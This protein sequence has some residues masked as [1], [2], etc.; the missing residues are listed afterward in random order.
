MK[1]DPT[2][3]RKAIR[4]KS[5]RQEWQRDAWA[6]YRQIPIVH[7]AHDYYGNVVSR[8][9]LYAGYQSDPDDPPIPLDDLGEASE[10]PE[11]S[12]DATNAAAVDEMQRLDQASDGGL[13]GL[14][15]DFAVNLSLV[16]E[17][18]LYGREDPDSPTGETFAVYST[19][20]FKASES[21]YAIYRPG[22]SSS[23]LGVA[24][25]PD[26]YVLRV[27]RRLRQFRDLA[28]APMMALLDD[29]DNLFLLTR[30]L[31]AI[32]QSR[33]H[34]GILITP[35]E[36]HFAQRATDPNAEGQARDVPFIEQLNQALVTSIQDPA[37]PSAVT[38]FHVDAPAASIGE[39]RWMDLGRGY[40]ENI[41]AQIEGV[42]E[43][44]AGGLDLPPEVITGH[45][46]TTFANAWQIAEET[47]KAHI[48]PLVQVICRALTDGYLK[49][50]LEARGL[51][52]QGYSV[53][54]DPSALIGHPDLFA[55]M[56]EMHT[57]YVVSDDALRRAGGA[58]DDDA[59]EDE[60]IQRRL[61][62][63][64][65]E[66]VTIRE[67]G[68]APAGE[69]QKDPELD[70]GNAGTPAVT[71]TTGKTPPASATTT[72]PKALT[73]AGQRAPALD[74]LGPRLAQIDQDLRAR[75]QTLADSALQRALE[76]AGAMVARKARPGRASSGKLDVKLSELAQH[77]GRDKV[78]AMGLDED[79]L[80]D[81]ELGELEPEYRKLTKRALAA[82]LLAGARAV[83]DGT[84]DEDRQ[85]S[86]S[87][88]QDA[89]IAGG[90]A[91]LSAAVLSAAHDQLFT[92]AQTPAGPGEIDLSARVSPSAIRESLATAGGALASA[93]ST[94]APPGGVATGKIVMDAFREALQI[95]PNGWQWVYGYP[96]KPFEP[97]EALEG[98]EFSSWEDDALLNDGDWPDV[99]Y[100]RPGD[101]NGCACAYIAMF[102][103]DRQNDEELPEEGD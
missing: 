44:I 51:D 54:Y 90:F 74:T 55:N 27:W 64:Q 48:E 49:P 60:E 40:G 79:R 69:V 95:L 22:D 66:R 102:A 46:N 52:P 5:L 91:I 98:V 33:I 87:V 20:E 70:K 14:A 2:D 83:P 77:Y 24:I 93:S 18:F 57:A 41:L 92:P 89:W 23:S 61:Y 37:S 15:G 17:A 88:E 50:A 13:A 53:W 67:Q 9:R 78:I 31:K 8:V 73:A 19:E 59:P 6:F 58:N 86:L 65:Q 99:T 39:A 38:P 10:K 21:G 7:Y 94:G 11:G 103:S 25:G 30:V 16:G 97:H 45:A 96:D 35:S 42:R 62:I 34:G 82:A 36:W 80:I 63:A 72:P 47:F 84:L 29:C 100:F 68:V 3:L 4:V 1:L 101:H 71:P 85:R 43:A 76:R 26:D 75:V 32:S 81:G 12:N 56:K 28:D